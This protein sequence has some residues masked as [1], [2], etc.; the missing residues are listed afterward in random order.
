MTRP[1]RGSS[2]PETACVATHVIHMCIEL[3]QESP[4]CFRSAPAVTTPVLLL[5]TTFSW[6]THARALLCAQFFGLADI[7]LSSPLVPA[8]TVASFVKRFARLGMRASPAGAML[9]IAF[10]HNLIR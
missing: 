9:A 10:I 1:C 4:A 7:F 6:Q 3:V 5:F 2:P 8:Y